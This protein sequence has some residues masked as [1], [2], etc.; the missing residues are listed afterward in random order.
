MGVP[1]GA[2]PRKGGPQECQKAI[3]SGF[4]GPVLGT[5]LGHLG[6]LSAPVCGPFFNT[7]LGALLERPWVVFSQIW[8]QLWLNFGCIL[9][10]FWE[11]LR[12]VKI[13]LSLKAGASF[14]TPADLKIIVFLTSFPR[15]LRSTPW[16]L[17]WQ[18]LARFY[19]DLGVPW[20]SSF[21]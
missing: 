10:L 8:D 16:S 17:F 13:E 19:L 9:G 12:K 5:F 18:S 15:S 4:L 3:R 14:T 20:G 11:T 6:S 1:L 2:R 7:F 21:L